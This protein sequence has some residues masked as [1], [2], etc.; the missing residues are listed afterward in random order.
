MKLPLVLI[1]TL[2]GKAKKKKH[3]E[4]DEKKVAFVFTNKQLAD[5]CHRTAMARF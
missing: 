5:K 2:L 1:I 3:V 4:I